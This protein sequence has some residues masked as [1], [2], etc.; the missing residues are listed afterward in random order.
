MPR[1][2]SIVSLIALAA[3]A[4]QLPRS[5]PVT[6]QR[7]TV[8]FDTSTT[9]EGTF[10]LETGVIVDPG[11]SFDSPNTLKYGTSID[12]ELF[13]GWS[14]LQWFE[15][16]GPDGEGSGDLVLGARHRV[17]DAEGAM[18]SG[19]VVL[20]GKLPTASSAEGLGSGEVDLRLGMVINRQFG[21]VNAKAFYQYGALG[22]PGGTGTTSE[23]T[24]TLTAGFPL[25]DR[26]SGF[27]EVAAIS[28]PASRTD[29]VFT[30]IGAAFAAEPWLVV[31]WGVTIGLS[32]DAPDLQLFLGATYNFGGWRRGGN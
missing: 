17:F 19:A 31:D 12:T 22:V 6:P 16:P 1:L 18:P 30:I 32:E 21:P 25:A 27:A 4:C 28:V 7:P 29:S 13:A 11:T 10:E 3:S 20:T 24:A 15:Q 23:H 26:L 5:A 2:R 9:A 14:P 8:S